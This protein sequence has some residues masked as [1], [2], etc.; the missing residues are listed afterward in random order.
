MPVHSERG[1]RGMALHVLDPDAGREWV[2]SVKPRPFH[3]GER[4]PVPFIQGS[5]WVLGPI[6]MGLENLPPPTGVRTPDCPARGVSLCRLC[7]PDRKKKL[8]YINMN[9]ELYTGKLFTNWVIQSG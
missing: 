5:G 9:T 7:Y 2:V 6:W 8:V 1:V 3:L 4:D